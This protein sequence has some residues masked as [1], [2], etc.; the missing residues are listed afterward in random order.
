MKYIFYIVFF[1]VLAFSCQNKPELMCE[2]SHQ[3]PHIM[4]DGLRYA[5]SNEEA[6]DWFLNSKRASNEVKKVDWNW[7]ELGP[8]MTPPE[9]QTSKALKERYKGRGNGTGR[10]NNI[11]INRVYENQVFA[12]SPTGGLFCSRDSGKTWQNG[13]TDEL[14]VSGVSAVT[15]NPA[16][17]SNWIISTGD[18]D[19]QFVFSDGVYR[20]FDSGNHWEKINGHSTFKLPIESHPFG[21]H[22]SE[23][24]AHPCD[25][26]KQFVVSNKGFY[27][28]GNSLDQVEK[29]KW[30]KEFEGAYY[31]IEISP[32]NEAIV[33]VGG[34]SLLISEDC[35]K[36]FKKIERPKLKEEE[37]YGL[38][39]MNIEFNPE[40][41]EKIYVAI[42]RKKGLGSGGIGTGF[43]FEFDLLTHSWK[44]IR[45]LRKVGNIIPTRGRAFEVSPN[46]E[47]L[48]LLGNVK[49][50]YRSLDGG[51]T[52]EKVAPNQMHDDIHDFEFFKN[53]KKIL[54]AHDGGVSVS[55]DYGQSWTLSDNGIGAANVHGIDVSSGINPMIIYGAYDTGTTLYKNG[56]WQH[57]GF[58]DGFQAVIDHSDSSRM[59]LSMQN[60]GLYYSQNASQFE[61]KSRAKGLKA[62]WHTWVK[63]NPQKSNALYV[64]GSD[65]ARSLDFGESWELICEPEKDLGIRE[66]PWRFF[67]DENDANL[68]FAVVLGKTRFDD[69]L[70]Y[71]D[72]VND[73][74]DVKWTKL[75]KLPHANWVSSI[76]PSNECE[77]CHYITFISYEAHGKL[78][79][80]NGESYQSVENKL[81]KSSIKSAVID[82]ETDRIYIGTTS[83]VYTKS[84]LETDWVLLSG[85]PS[86]RANSMKL[87]YQAR[88]LFVGTFGR[89][90]WKAPMF[91]N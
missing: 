90:V 59:V 14:P 10:V 37:K 25:F 17:S 43:L 82:K 24:V 3:E 72:N 91:P 46:K 61:S 42:S 45:E 78:F 51:I 89:G 31:D 77:T 13:G 5:A 64:S 12:C 67:L 75:S 83:G 1:Q 58:G 11:V 16:D 4:D 32:H 80:F 84:K 65:I 81:G 36:S 85:L 74:S 60:G 40:D 22:I 18:G 20:T 34:E 68:M 54:A 49:P 39:R 79:Y 33:T 47:K 9:G 15:V 71:S 23:I 44:E 55:K 62:S 63:Q 38:V 57:V 56:E 28:C 35:G 52:F 88:E 27:K 41:E 26:N 8:T 69:F 2:T 53:S 21:V 29:I 76:L 70:Y 48:M 73:T 86:A 66:K 7:V 19:D 6:W 50:V 30:I 87:N